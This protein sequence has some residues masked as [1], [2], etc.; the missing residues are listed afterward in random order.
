MVMA[1]VLVQRDKFFA[2]NQG[3]GWGVELEMLFL[4]GSVAIFFLGSGRYAVS[5]GKGR[6]D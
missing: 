2:R 5:R 1:I 3:G 6:W 4:L